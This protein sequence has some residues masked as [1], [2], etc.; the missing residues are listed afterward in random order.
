MGAATGS[1]VKLLSKPLDLDQCLKLFAAPD[2]LDPENMWRCPRCQEFVCARKKMDIWTT[3]KC[4]IVHL[5]RFT[6]LAKVDVEVIYPDELDLTPYVVGPQHTTREGLKYRLYGVSEHFGG[7]QG[8]HYTA[9][10]KVIPAG[11]DDGSWFYF[12]DSHCQPADTKA[13]HSAAAYMLFYQRVG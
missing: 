9:H 1:S 11:T 5:K 4:L 8:G 13:A 7:M 12:N 3:P 2:D 10:A 6:A